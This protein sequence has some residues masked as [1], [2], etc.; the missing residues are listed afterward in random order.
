MPIR[1][2]RQPE[3]VL[4][5]VSKPARKVNVYYAKGDA[6]KSA[7]EIALDHGFVGTEQEWLDTL[8]TIDALDEHVNSSTPHPTYDDLPSLTL[9]F[10]NGLN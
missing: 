10:E 5:V 7:Y 6:G 4:T 2:V 8:L 1:I 3:T 9:L